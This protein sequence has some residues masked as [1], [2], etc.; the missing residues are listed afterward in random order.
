MFKNFIRNIINNKKCI[1]CGSFEFLPGPKG[2][3]SPINK[4]NPQCKKCGSLERHRI[5]RKIYNYIPRNWFKN[6]KILQFSN[7]QSIDK[8][9]FNDYE[10]ST[11]MGQNSLDLENIERKNDSYDFIICNH[12]LEHIKDDYKA[13]KEILRIS[14]PH[15]I[16]QLAVP[17]P[18]LIDKTR[19][20]GFPDKEKFYHYRI[21]GKDFL[22]RFKNKI[23]FYYLSIIDNDPITEE[24][25]IIYFI[26]RTNE[27]LKRI[28][29]FF[30]NKIIRDNNIVI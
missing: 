30:P 4:K 13:F 9:W 29:L 26:S 5:I 10:L 28:S 19:D 23:K 7:D 14:K 15:A 1:I 6:K 2:R 20:W 24:K 8:N 16:I 18:L 21:Y 3:V 27:S 12:V 17:T 11:Y 22:N 25:D